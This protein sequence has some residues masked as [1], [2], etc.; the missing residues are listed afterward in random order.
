MQ[1]IQLEIKDEYVEYVI[2]FLRLLPENVAKISTFT[3]LKSNESYDDEL[4]S[5]IEDIKNNNVQTLSREELF[6]TI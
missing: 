4:L 1:T 3:H 6:N 5:R 2:N